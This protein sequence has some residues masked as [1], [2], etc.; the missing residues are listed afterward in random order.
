MRWF[1]LLVMLSACAPR[2][3]TLPPTMRQIEDYTLQGWREANQPD[4]GQC[5][6]ATKVRWAASV[7]EFEALC[8]ATIGLEP[9]SAGDTLNTEVDSSAACVAFYRQNRGL[10]ALD[11]PYVLL[12][13]NQPLFDGEGS[14]VSHEFLHILF[15]CTKGQGVRDRFNGN[16]TDI[17]VWKG[18][19]SAH[20]RARQ[21]IL[22]W[23]GLQ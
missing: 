5:L 13:P 6:V 9:S 10:D 16:H 3:V 19:A 17:S 14:V 1:L 2:P 18:P 11:I 7:A 4:P 21:L 20:G 22:R 12:H 8:E 23:R 15:S